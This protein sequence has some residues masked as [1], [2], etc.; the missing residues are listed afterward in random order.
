MNKNNHPYIQETVIRRTA[1]E[2]VVTAQLKC[3][4]TNGAVNKTLNSSG[5]F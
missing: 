3:G 5:Q 2:I 4:K 1:I